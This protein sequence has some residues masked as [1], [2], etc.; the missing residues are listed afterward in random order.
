[1]GI[2]LDHLG[3]IWEP[4]V[5]FL[6]FGGHLGS[7]W[8]HLGVIL[9]LWDHLGV[10]LEPWGPLGIIFESSGTHFGCL[11]G[12]LGIILEVSGVHFGSILVT[13]G[14]SWGGRAQRGLPGRAQRSHLVD[15]CQNAGFRYVI[16]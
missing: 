15:V 9:D 6:S 5:N 11:G 13:P 16:F 10:I 3:L 4:L 2:I 1:M 14:G 7:L 12:H 8:A